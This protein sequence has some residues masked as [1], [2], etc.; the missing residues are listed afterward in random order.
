LNVPS[1]DLAADFMEEIVLSLTSNGFI[2]YEI[3]NYAKEVFACKHNQA[4]WNS[5]DY[6]GLGPGAHS[7]V[8]TFQG[9]IK[10]STKR[11]SNQSM[12]ESYLQKPNNCVAWSES[13]SGAS[14]VFEEIMLGL[15]QNEGLRLSTLVGRL[16][17][18]QTAALS[19]LVQ[20]LKQEDFL[21]S[22][23]DQERIVLSKKGI[24]IADSI[25][26]KFA[27]TLL[28]AMEAEIGSISI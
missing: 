20:Q 24:M 26:G 28:Q 19:I 18:F 15:R 17:S 7:A 5:K 14:L 8:A 22:L 13:I 10:T 23:Q 25:I 27:E 12:P 11:W 6:L 4:Y 9:G 2:H 1:N 3:S 21:V 16:N